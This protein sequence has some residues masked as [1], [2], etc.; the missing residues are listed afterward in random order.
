MNL[1]IKSIKT[2]RIL[3]NVLYDRLND[4]DLNTDERDALEPLFDELYYFLAMEE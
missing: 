1:K 4:D 2:A 3:A